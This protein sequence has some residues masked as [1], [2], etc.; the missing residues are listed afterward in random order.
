VAIKTLTNLLEPAAY[1][2]LALGVTIA[3]LVQMFMYGPIDQTVLRFV[4]VHRERGSLVV[5]F[6][7]LKRIHG[8][9]VLGAI[10]V[11]IPAA[12]V[13]YLRL[14][15]EWAWLVM[16]ACLF[17]IGTGFYGTL[18][19]L[20]NGFRQRR[21]VALHQ[22]FDAWLRLCLAVAAVTVLGA[23][24]GAA[25]LGYVLAA[26]VL[27]LSLLY[28]SMKLPALSQHGNVVT[29]QQDAV[30]STIDEFLEFGKP[31][32]Y[33]ALF[34]LVSAYADRWIVFGALGEEAVGRYVVIYQLANAPI[35]LTVGIMNQF[36]VPLIFD[37]AGAFVTDAQSNESTRLL[38]QVVGVFVGM[39]LVLVAATYVFSET[40]VRFFTAPEFLSYHYVL[41]IMVLGVGTF[42]LAQLLVVKGLSH[43][44]TERYVAPKLLQAIVLLGLLWLL[45]KWMGIV[46]V[47]W[48]ILFSSIV[49]LGS[50]LRVNRAIGRITSPAFARTGPS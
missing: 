18:V 28:C 36:V 25:L 9:V 47:P 6:A 7:A 26:V 4:S 39:M 8:L 17:G 27:A 45:T 22:G 43:N 2:E 14:G 3:G 21:I 15:L 37:R 42:Q 29:Q 44:A 23:T 1:G 31:F 24:G 33:F 13:V 35:V 48:A 40:I 19:S 38:Y 32:L 10:P 50:V 5:F 41:W 49:Y 11:L 20:H 16:V 34:G 12:G 46:G 30:Q